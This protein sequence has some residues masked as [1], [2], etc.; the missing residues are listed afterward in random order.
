MLQYLLGKR[1]SPTSYACVDVLK[2]KNANRLPM[3][4]KQV[5]TKCH[6]LSSLQSLVIITVV[7]QFGFCTNESKQFSHT[8]LKLGDTDDD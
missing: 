7:S 1:P 4:Y 2:F 8:E 5:K 3:N 6:M